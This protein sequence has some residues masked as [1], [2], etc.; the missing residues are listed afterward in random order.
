[1]IGILSFK[2]LP[3]F[4]EGEFR[5]GGTALSNTSVVKK[6]YRQKGRYGLGNG[7]D[8]IVFHVSREQRMRGADD[9]PRPLI[10]RVGVEKASLQPATCTGAVNMELKESHPQPSS[11]GDKSLRGESSILSSKLSLDVLFFIAVF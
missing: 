8:D 1:M 5:T 7:S 2:L 11:I 9:Y 4:I 10:F 6:Q 3:I